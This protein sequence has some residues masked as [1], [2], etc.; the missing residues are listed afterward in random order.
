MTKEAS[1]KKN[2]YS[3]F[4]Y[5]LKK[6]TW[7]I[8]LKP[9]VNKV[10]SNVLSSLLV[11]IITFYAVNFGY[12]IINRYAFNRFSEDQLRQM[13]AAQVGSEDFAFE[14]VRFDQDETESI[15][16]LV[17]SN[18]ETDE[19]GIPDLKQ[20]GIVPA[21]LAIFE[22][23]AKK[24]LDKILFD[25][26]LYQL[27]QQFEL[28][29]FRQGI[30]YMLE[31]S[32]LEVIDLFNDNEEE[33][34]FC[35][36]YAGGGSGTNYECS[37][38]DGKQFYE[39]FP[40]EVVDSPRPESD[41]FTIDQ[42]ISNFEFLESRDSPIFSSIHSDTIYSFN[43]EKDKM[44]FLEM[45]WDEDESHASPHL[46]DIYSYTIHRLPESRKSVMGSE[47]SMF[48]TGGYVRRTKENERGLPIDVLINDFILK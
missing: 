6:K 13:I 27:R 18:L 1:H 5:D 17:N 7:T 3:H 29:P 8:C 30:D 4:F 19:Y 39:P 38:Y 34:F 46:Y 42:C 16:V 47:T 31:S 40:N 23:V 35:L 11:L 33:V 12:R 32:S 36:V 22:P 24:P 45:F 37:I 48:F 20:Q 44:I 10:L 43:D 15:A 41:C 28:I 26:E 2:R 25:S 9:F 21:I 14:K